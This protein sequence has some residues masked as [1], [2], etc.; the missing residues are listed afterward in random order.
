V[1]RFKQ[2][3]EVPHDPWEQLGLAI[4]KIIQSWWTERA[5]K[6]RDIHNLPDDVKT[7]VIVQ[8]MIYGN[9]NAFSGSGVAMTRNPATGEKGLC[10]EY[11]PNATGEDLIAG[12]R[13]PLTLFDLYK[14]QSTLYEKLNHI[15]IVLENHYRDVQV[16]EIFFNEF[17]PSNK[18]L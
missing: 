10:G 18:Y 2:V 11:L 9:R 17:W 14:E 3:C 12:I 5:T 16:K 4:R 1:N 7:G 6:Y 15:A 8:S 13:T